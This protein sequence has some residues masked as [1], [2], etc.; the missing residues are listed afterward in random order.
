LIFRT[1]IVAI[2]IFV[3]EFN[4]DYLHWPLKERHIY[5]RWLKETSWGHLFQRYASEGY[6]ASP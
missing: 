6:L 4:H 1:P 5:E 2:P 3:S